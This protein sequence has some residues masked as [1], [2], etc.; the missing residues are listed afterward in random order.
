MRAGVYAD[1]AR[2]AAS[3]THSAGNRKRVDSHAPPP[4]RP[5]TPRR[6]FI[7]GR[8]DDDQLILKP[9]P[10]KV[11]FPAHAYLTGTNSDEVRFRRKCRYREHNPAVFVIRTALGRSSIFKANS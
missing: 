1:S 2:D 5:S 9:P 10:E 11:V 7:D 6:L 4:T 8:V 3:R